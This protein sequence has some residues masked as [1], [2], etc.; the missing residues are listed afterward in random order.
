[1]HCLRVNI[2]KPN[3]H[4][5]L[6]ATHWFWKCSVKNISTFFWYSLNVFSLSL[7]STPQYSQRKRLGLGSWLNQNKIRHN[8]SFLSL[9]T[10]WT[11]ISRDGS[12]WL[13]DSSCIHV[14]CGAHFATPTQSQIGSLYPQFLFHNPGSSVSIGGFHLIPI[15]IPFFFCFPWRH[16]PKDWGL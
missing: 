3:L 10:N 13:E 6:L 15:L 7:P 8:L 9:N 12:G 2:M 11:F 5:T 1:M 4:R 14:S 16:C